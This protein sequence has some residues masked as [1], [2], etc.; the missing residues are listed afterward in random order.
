MNITIHLMAREEKILLERL[1]ELYLYEFSQYSQEDVSEYGCYGYSHIDDYWNEKGRYPYLI[2]ADGKIAGFALICPHCD[3]R[4][5]ED[6][7][8]IGEFFILLKYRRKGIGQKVAIQLFDRHRGCWEI[9]YWKNNLPAGR[10]WKKVVETYTD[11]HYETCGT[12]E[13]R[14]QGFTFEN[15]GAH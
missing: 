8:S 2:R 10:F 15:Q 14:N 12:K 7:R 4:R 5:E 1:M 13:S 6:A 9:C 3:Y 11:K